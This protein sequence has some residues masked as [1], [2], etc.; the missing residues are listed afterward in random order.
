[1]SERTPEETLAWLD[2]V[3][4]P[5]YPLTEEENQE[6]I[7]LARRGVKAEHECKICNSGE[8]GMRIADLME[9]LEAQIADGSRQYALLKEVWTKDYNEMKEHLE[10][11]MAEMRPIVETELK[12]LTSGYP[13]L[14]KEEKT[15]LA[16]ALSSDAG[17]DWLSPDKAKSLKASIERAMQLMLAQTFGDG[18]H[19]WSE[20]SREGQPYF[21]LSHA[22]GILEETR[23]SSK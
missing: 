15:L 1:M 6:I 19:T 12:R 2:Q 3:A 21:I 14:F 13:K 16:R 10:A 7:A 5:F 9:R 17:K 8:R 11:Q 20:S 23:C 22:L 4:K 18:L